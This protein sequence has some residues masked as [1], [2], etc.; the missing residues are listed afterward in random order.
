M[1]FTKLLLGSLLFLGTNAIGQTE[2]SD[3]LGVIGDNLDLYAV[4]DAFKNAESMESFEKTINDP[5][6]KINNLDLNEDE[7]VDYIQVID[8]M[9]ES[10]HAIILRIELSEDESQDVAVI[11]LEKTDDETANIQLVGDEDIYG[12]NYIVEPLEE[13]VQGQMPPV[14]IVLNVWHWPCV[15]FI[16]GPSYKP[17]VSPWRYRHYP[18]YWKPWRPYKWRTYHGY[19]KHHHQHYH[20]VHVHRNGHAH[21]VYHKHKKSWKNIKNHPHHHHHKNHANHNGHKN[22]NNNGQ[23]KNNAN[24]N[25]NGNKQKTNKGQ[26]KNPNGGQKKSPPQNKGGKKNKR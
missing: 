14:V 3:S 15:K 23:K 19:H 6:N 2:E 12:E 25:K 7:E 1:K 10:A 11:E 18:A 20:V 9:E 16:Y 8:N 21:K 4:M 17:W 5:D 22:G 24:G 26:K 13:K